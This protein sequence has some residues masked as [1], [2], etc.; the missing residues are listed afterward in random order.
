MPPPALW[1]ISRSLICSSGSNSFSAGRA[2]ST[3]FPS[4]APEASE[5]LDCR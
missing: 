5:A 2:P 4:A 1:A 3:S